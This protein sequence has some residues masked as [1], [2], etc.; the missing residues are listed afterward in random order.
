MILL[1]IWFPLWCSCWCHIWLCNFVLFKFLNYHSRGI[2]LCMTQFDF[3]SLSRSW[4]RSCIRFLATLWFQLYSIPALTFLILDWLIESVETLKVHLTIFWRSSL[5]IL[6]RILGC[7]TNNLWSFSRCS[8][9]IE[10]ISALSVLLRNYY[11]SGD[12]NRILTMF[13]SVKINIIGA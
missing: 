1:N 5:R 9:K 10:L 12:Y 11:W 4:S 6:M 13:N 2:Q 7:S 8:S 3:F